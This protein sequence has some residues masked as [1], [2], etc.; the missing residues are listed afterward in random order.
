ML[1][2]SIL[3]ILK[4]KNKKSFY[5]RQK[6]DPL[7][8]QVCLLH[9]SQLHLIL[10]SESL[11]SCT[12]HEVRHCHGHCVL[13]SSPEKWN[14]RICQCIHLEIYFKKWLIWLWVWQMQSW[15]GRPR[16]WRPRE[17]HWAMQSEGRLSPSS[18]SSIFA[19]KALYELKPH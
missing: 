13:Q 9:I 16:D 3:F 2:F 10:A 4:I 1:C 11:S 6:F 5:A 19:W 14:S 15:H 18:V 17:E 8:T 12:A 7:S